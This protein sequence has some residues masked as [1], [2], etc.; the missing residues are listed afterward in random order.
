[1]LVGI[2][3]DNTII[4]YDNSLHG[5]AVKLG[6]LSADTPKVKRL[7]RD[8]VRSKHSDIEWQKLQIAIYGTHVDRAEL[9]P[10]V[11]NFLRGL[12]E[13][14]IKFKIVSHKTRY[15]N[16]GNSKVDLRASAIEFLRQHN[17]FS[18]TGLAMSEGDVFF[19]PTRMEKI[20]AIREL[21]C[22]LFIDDLKELYLEP[23]FPPQTTKILFSEERN[24]NLPDVT[25]LSDFTQ[26]SNFLFKG[27][28]DGRF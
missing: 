9:M 28:E 19:L 3:L 16:Y 12:K 24:L 21:G 6:L 7:I 26:I 15:P 10:G 18:A 1:M 22:S 27:I 23:D 20:S 25:V 8:K 13:R 17:F 2:D 11:W 4:R 5:I 14:N